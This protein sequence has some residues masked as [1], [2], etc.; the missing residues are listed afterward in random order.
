MGITR[1]TK[2]VKTLLKEFEDTQNAISVV[3]L[4]ERLH[5]TMNKTTVY[6][7]LERL[8]DDGM[9]HSF[10]G[11][12]GLKWYAKCTAEDSEQNIHSHPHF[13]C[14]DCSKTTCLSTDE[15][16]ISISSVSNYKID[17]MELLLIGH[18]GSCTS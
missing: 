3:D 7:I 6:R 12:E 10:K 9:L 18:C 13:Q 17:K 1:K 2:S 4:V 16:D 14:R 8:E 5:L 11:K 15:V